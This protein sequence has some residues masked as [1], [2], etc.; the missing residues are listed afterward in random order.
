MPRAK[1]TRRPDGRYATKIYL[2][3]ENGKPK[4]KYLYAATVTELERKS[5]ELRYAMHKGSDIMSGDLAFRVWA[6]R[7]LRLK[8][9]KV[10]EA[11]YAGI[12]GRVAFWKN[13]VGDLPISRITRSDLQ[14]PFDRLAKLNPRTKRPTGKKTL[15]DYRLTAAGVFEL[16][17]S[18]RAV[19]YNPAKFL[20]I[21]AAGEKHTRRALTDEEQQWILNTPHRAQTAAMIMMLA[22][23]RRGELIPLQVADVDLIAGTIRIN[24][25]VKMVNGKP[26]IKSGGKTAAANRIVNVPRVLID[27]LRPVLRG[28]SPFALVCSDTRG[29]ML[30]E[31]TFR[32]MWDSYLK[33]LNFKNGKFT[34]SPTSKFQPQ[35]IP[36]VIPRITP[37]ML[38]HTC[39]TNLILAG[40]D[41]ITVKNLLGHA[42]IS[43]T[44][45]I[46]THVTEEHK[47][48]ETEKL[49]AFFAAKKISV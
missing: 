40:V 39:T 7:F 25:S 2:G 14:E 34:N 35:G 37:H 33:E 29:K 44:L 20:E 16:A 31:A 28:R 23:L 11:Y 48:S 10:A 18:D 46:Y 17:I 45:N 30:S 1:Y 21:S 8:K 32:I 13:E 4:Y 9:P 27:Y 3:I 47:E 19:S 49:N 12:A 5:E 26:I 22:G 15:V 42:D 36:T 43:T 24:K 41:P 6:D 38:R